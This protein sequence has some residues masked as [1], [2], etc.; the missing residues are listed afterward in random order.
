M[1]A[2]SADPYE[3]LHYAAFH[4]GLHYLPKYQL[5][6]IVAFY[7][8]FCLQNNNGAKLKFMLIHILHLLTN[9]E[10]ILIFDKLNVLSNFAVL[11]M[12]C[13]YSNFKLT[14]VRV[15]MGEN[16]IIHL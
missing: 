15:S 14:K 10:M 13:L 5:N 4:L 11:I 16:A 8:K 6:L 2:N 1:L 9:A 3:M 7:H 12:Y